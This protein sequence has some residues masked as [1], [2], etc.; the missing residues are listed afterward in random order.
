ML[1]GS[2]TLEVFNYY[3]FI[4]GLLSYLAE[5]IHFFRIC[6]CCHPEKRYRST[7][8]LRKHMVDKGHTMIGAEPEEISQFYLF[9]DGEFEDADDGNLNMELNV[10]SVPYDEDIDERYKFLFLI[11][12]VLMTMNWNYH[13]V[14]L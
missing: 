13:Q 3:L 2:L 11:L 4:L 5:K 10:L 6:L 14:V 8:A 1:S 9:E 7:D 12:L